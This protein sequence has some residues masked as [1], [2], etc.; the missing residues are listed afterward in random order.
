MARGA[1]FALRSPIAMLSDQAQAAL[2]TLTAALAGRPE[3]EKAVRRRWRA[4]GRVGV[5]GHVEA[6]LPENL[7]AA[8]DTLGLACLSML[9]EASAD[10]TKTNPVSMTSGRL[11]PSTPKL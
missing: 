11:I 4:G 9:H 6:A 8:S 1:Q 2:E 5:A 10:S 7:R 3:L